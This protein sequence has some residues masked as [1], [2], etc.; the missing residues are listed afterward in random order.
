MPVLS[1]I[2]SPT[3]N[4]ERR[5]I[6]RKMDYG[7]DKPCKRSYQWLKFERKF[8]KKGRIREEQAPQEDLGI[9][10]TLANT[11]IFSVRWHGK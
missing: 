8:L 3:C 9:W 4:R 1:S 6:G 10:L 11:A 5:R 7:R 2:G